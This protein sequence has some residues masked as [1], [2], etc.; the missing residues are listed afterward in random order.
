[1]SLPTPGV[2]GHGT[3]CP[4]SCCVRQRGTKP[5]VWLKVRR[6]PGRGLGKNRMLT[7]HNMS[8]LAT[9]TRFAE[10]GAYPG[11]LFGCFARKLPGLHKNARNQFCVCSS[12]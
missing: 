3:W 10:P 6:I 4:G 12:S 5:A 9:G 1:M 11:V 8:F 7:G 2:D